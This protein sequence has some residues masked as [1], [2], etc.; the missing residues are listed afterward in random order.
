MASPLHAA[1]LENEDDIILPRSAGE[2]YVEG[3]SNH[4]PIKN[5]RQKIICGALRSVSDIRDRQ[6]MLSFL[7]DDG[8]S[9]LALVWAKVWVSTRIFS[10]QGRYYIYIYIHG[11]CHL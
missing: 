5:V 2:Y 9:L 6:R 8:W 1:L 4:Y 11:A 3:L 7:L 10:K